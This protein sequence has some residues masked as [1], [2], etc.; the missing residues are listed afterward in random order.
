MGVGGKELLG[1]SEDLRSFI[2]VSF[3]CTM[4]TPALSQQACIQAS[5][6]FR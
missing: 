6:A 4:E 2:V 1:A 3:L 5:R